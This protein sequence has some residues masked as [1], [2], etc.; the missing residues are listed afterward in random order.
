MRGILGIVGCYWEALVYS[1]KLWRVHF[2]AT[3]PI[4]MG[5]GLYWSILVHSRG[6]WEHLGGCREDFGNPLEILGGT[7]L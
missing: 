1:G 6:Y 3:Q 2:G 4:L 7:G 5:T